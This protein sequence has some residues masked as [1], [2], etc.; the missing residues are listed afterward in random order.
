MSNLGVY[1]SSACCS[2]E[3]AQSPGVGK[4]AASDRQQ[5]VPGAKQTAMQSRHAATKVSSQSMARADA[6]QK[7]SLSLQART[8]VLPYTGSC[9]QADML[10]GQCLGGL[11]SWY[12]TTGTAVVREAIKVG[13][14]FL[15]ENTKCDICIS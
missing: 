12:S 4:G 13:L 10:P 7:P 15:C 14:P 6:K 9:S 5:Q 2:D 3:R 11:Q 8:G 1:A